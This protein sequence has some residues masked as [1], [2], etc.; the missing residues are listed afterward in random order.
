MSLL[1]RV[2]W[3]RP[4]ASVEDVR[5]IARRR[6]PRPVFDFIDGGAEDEVT[7]ADN[8][9]GF[10]RFR[11]QPQALTDVSVRSQRVT[12]LGLELELPVLLAPA[13]LARLAHPGGE[14]AAARAAAAAG[15]VFTL[16]TAASASI[17]EVAAASKGPLWL[18]LYVWSDRGATRDLVAR[19]DAAGYHSLCFTID[20]P[21]S[22]QRERDL[23]NGLTIPPRPAGSTLVEYARHP[24][25]V[26]HALLG[27]PITFANFLGATP[28][29][30]DGAV[31]L[32]KYV[33]SQLNPSMS[34]DDL[35]WL[36]ET[37]QRPLLVKGVMTAGDA[38][39]AVDL[40]A[41]A[42]IVSNHG[43]RQLDGLPATVDVL[44]EIVDAVGDRAEVL[45]DS[46]VRRGADV[47]KALALGAR[48]VLVGRPYLYGLAMSGEAGALQVLRMLAAEIDRVQ[49]LLGVPDVR[50]LHPG[51]IRT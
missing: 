10:E 37:W 28:G 9:A 35:Q 12:V 14:V 2:G 47:V 31:A 16:S 30:G 7:L 24:A 22:G 17:E 32:G 27:S 39:R 11:F 18:Q 21:M 40:G 23:R 48:A 33:N 26:R 5:A 6:L 41:D 34:W 44:A 19:A 49:A 50:S 51:F 46:G 43:G 13:G 45:L 3:R 42:L 36:R 20:V 29:Q 8:R 1:Q 25:W 4:P 15:T 38:R